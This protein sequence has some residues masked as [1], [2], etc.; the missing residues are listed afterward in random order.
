MKQLALVVMMVATAGPALGQSPP[1]AS[2]TSAAVSS[3]ALPALSPSEQA[4][5]LE[6]ARVTRVRAASKGVTGTQRATLSA[7]A[8][9]HDASIQMIDQSKTSFQTASGVEI[10][11][12]DYWGFNIA[13]YRLAVMVG[14]DRVPPSVARRF[15]GQ[16]AAFTWWVDDV[17]LDEQERVKQQRQPPDAGGWTAQIQILRVFDELIANTDRNQGNMLIDTQWKI[18]L[19]DHTRAFRTTPTLRQPSTIYRCEKSLLEGMRAL[20]S[21]VL[22]E[23]LGD[24][25]SRTQIEALLKRRDLIVSRIESLGPAAVFQLAAP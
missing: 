12:R 15:R 13:A 8:Y 23:Q 4:R 10:G 2:A 21:E 6:S 18:W 19:I 24:Y 11:F 14:L 9:T 1:P 22:L 25:L 20:S 7:A 5:F 16:D 17:M 3:A